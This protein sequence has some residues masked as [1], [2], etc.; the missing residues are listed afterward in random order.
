MSNLA[1]LLLG[2]HVCRGNINSDGFVVGKKK[3]RD[4]RVVGINP[5][6]RIQEVVYVNKDYE[7]GEIVQLTEANLCSLRPQFGKNKEFILAVF[8]LTVKA[9]HTIGS[10]TFKLYRYEIRRMHSRK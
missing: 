8:G 5:I 3:A 4:Y 7:L 2:D 10:E 9:C 1:K 6:P